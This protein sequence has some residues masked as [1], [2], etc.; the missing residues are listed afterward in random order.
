MITTLLDLLGA[1]LVLCA[2][3]LFVAQ[4]SIPGALG[5]AGAGVLVLSWLIDRRAP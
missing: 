2:V 1:L 3:A 5:A 4:W